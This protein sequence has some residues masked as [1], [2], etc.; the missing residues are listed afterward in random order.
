PAYGRTGTSVDELINFTPELRAEAEKVAARYKMGAP[1]SPA[2]VGTP[3]GE[4]GD[5]R[6]RLFRRPDV[7]KLEDPL[8]TLVAGCC[9]GGTGWP[10]GSY[11]P[12]THMLYTFTWANVT[13]LGL[14]PPAP[15]QSEMNYVSGVAR[16]AG[17][18]GGPRGPAG[19]GFRGLTVEG[20]PLFKPPY[21]SIV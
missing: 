19:E 11:D 18:A 12:E 3:E 7:S 13:S 15:G 5:R 14:V 9:Q 17:A 4:R 2:V 6:A 1:F 10:G 8:A 21:G 16:P 20:L